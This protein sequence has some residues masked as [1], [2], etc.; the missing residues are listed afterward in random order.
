MDRV[1]TFNPGV[2]F[3]FH[4]TPD[5]Q[6]PILPGK[7]MLTFD[8]LLLQADLHTMETPPPILWSVPAV[9]WAN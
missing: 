4:V 1:F 9:L 3:H 2:H 5:T 8:M 7:L 6:N